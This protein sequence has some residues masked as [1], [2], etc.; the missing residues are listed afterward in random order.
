MNWGNQ[1]CA[2]KMTW[3]LPD[4]SIVF[5]VQIE[6]TSKKKKRV[7]TQTETVFLPSAL[8]MLVDKIAQKIWNRPKFWCKIAQNMW[9][10]PKFCPKLR[11]LHQPREPVP[12]PPTST[13]M[14]WINI[15]KRSAS[16]QITESNFR[17]RL[18]LKVTAD[19][20]VLNSCL[21]MT[22]PNHAKTA[23]F[24][25]FHQQTNTAIH[26]TIQNIHDITDC[27]SSFQTYSLL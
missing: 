12:P 4:K 22:V 23:M 27:E 7:F 15:D 6:V 2:Q 24:F 5:S 26:C 3:K 1:S 10:W 13:P 18:F 21:L 8:K 25:C 17:G 16:K 20:T 9:N 11:H 19:A 14:T